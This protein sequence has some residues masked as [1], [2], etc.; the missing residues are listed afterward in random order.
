MSSAALKYLTT[1]Q[2]LADVARFIDTI[3][4]E[5]KFTNPRWVTFGGSYPG[6]LKFLRFI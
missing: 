2:A 6:N 4:K 1:K 3:N 5:Y